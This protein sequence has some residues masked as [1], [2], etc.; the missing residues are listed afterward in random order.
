MIPARDE[1][2]F[3]HFSEADKHWFRSWLDWTDANIEV[4]RNVRPILGQ[5]MLG[6]VDG[7]AAFMGDHGFIFLF[8]PNYRPLSAEFKL[9]ASIG[10]KEG[11]R[12]LLRQLY[13]DAEKGK[14][15]AGGTAN[16]FW[17]YGD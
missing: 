8:N 3:R 4:L 7:S 15:L 12:F 10:L 14:L 9:D 6:H 1:E 2:E 17:A 16:G 11:K 13:P 5:P